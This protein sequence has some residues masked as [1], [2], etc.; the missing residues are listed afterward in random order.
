MKSFLFGMEE[1][2]T[3][4]YP[5]RRKSSCV[6]P[7]N[8]QDGNFYVQHKG[9]D[10]PDVLPETGDYGTVQEEECE[11]KFA[12]RQHEVVSVRFGK[13]W[14]LTQ[15]R[16]YQTWSHSRESHAFFHAWFGQ[17]ILIQT[18]QFSL[19]GGVFSTRVCR[20]SSPSLACERS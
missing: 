16:S 4:V 7:I 9:G 3:L 8:R 13:L 20:I 19:C 14:Y 5:Q 17:V 6:H 18:F 15:S 11:D 2:A 12:D 1:E 10:H